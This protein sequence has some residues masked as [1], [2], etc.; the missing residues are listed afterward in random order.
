MMPFIFVSTR[1]WNALIARINQLEETVSDNQAH[2]DADVASINASLDNVEAEIATLK[3]ANPSVDF[4]GLDAVV[5]RL[6]G[7]ETAPPPPPA[8]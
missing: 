2:E 7:D 4:T 5:A 8:P 1:T 3:A 6:K